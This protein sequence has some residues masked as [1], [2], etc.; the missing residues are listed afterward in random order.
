MSLNFE[1]VRRSLFEDADAEEASL[2]QTFASE[3]E[4]GEKEEAGK[5]AAEFK[6]SSR[7]NLH[8]LLEAE[9]DEDEPADDEEDEGLFDEEGEDEPEDDEEDAGG[10]A[11][12]DAGGTGGTSGGG[13]GEPT[14]E[15]MDAEVAEAEEEVEEVTPSDTVDLGK[16]VDNALQGVFVD[17]ET[18]ARKSAQIQKESRY[19]LRRYLLEASSLDVDS[20][21]SDVARLVKNYD[22]LLDM[23]AIIINKAIQFITLNY[24]EEM[25]EE[26][27]ELLDVKH[28][29]A[30]GGEEEIPTPLAVG[31]SGGGG[32]GV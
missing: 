20:F 13:G 31:A 14:A 3:E 17:Y 11:G 7:F 29:I 25:A 5:E 4:A 28:G 22:N 30:I 26:F 19:S 8:A 6:E 1:K 12:A 2:Q 16:S 18:K 27:L 32:G 10:D 24:N 15:E 21:T 9:E 23:E